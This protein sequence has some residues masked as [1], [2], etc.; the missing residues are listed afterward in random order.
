MAT[1]TEELRTVF[2]WDT[3]D[4]DKGVQRVER[5]MTRLQEAEKK[6]A[7]KATP[8]AGNG[9][10]AYGVRDLSEGRTLNAM[11]RFGHVIGSNAGKIAD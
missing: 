3:K 6:T 11:Q 7:A 4:V 9:N 1:Q 2:T 5:A 8:G 10:F